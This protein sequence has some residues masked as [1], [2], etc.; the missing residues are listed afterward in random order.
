MCILHYGAKKKSTKLRERNKHWKVF[1]CENEHLFIGFFHLRWC[2]SG[3][4]NFC[5]SLDVF[6]PCLKKNANYW[7]T[8]MTLISLLFLLKWLFLGIIN[9]QAVRLLS[10]SIWGLLNKFHI[11][12]RKVKLRKSVRNIFRWVEGRGYFWT[13]KFDKLKFRKTFFEI[14]NAFQR[15]FLPEKWPK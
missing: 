2:I 6:L 1:K 11:S 3:K 14:V 15:K 12:N 9:Q 5:F 4:I 13:E 7:N 8:F 10:G